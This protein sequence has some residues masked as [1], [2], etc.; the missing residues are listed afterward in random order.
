MNGDKIIYLATGRL[1]T[2]DELN[3]MIAEAP[4]PI[5]FTMFLTIFG[6]RAQGKVTFLYNNN[7]TLPFGT[8]V[9]T[10]L[11]ICQQVRKVLELAIHSNVHLLPLILL[12][13]FLSVSTVRRQ[14]MQHWSCPKLIR[15]RV[16]LLRT[17]ISTLIH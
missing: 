10:G 14:T 4:G 3:S 16:E 2:E 5:N 15:S 7:F 9:V 1:C 13:N 12:H 11:Y 6:E 17:F 8:I